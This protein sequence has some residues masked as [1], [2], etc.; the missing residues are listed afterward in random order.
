MTEDDV[1]EAYAKIQQAQD[2]LEAYAKLK[3]LAISANASGYAGKFSVTLNMY[4]GK[5]LFRVGKNRPATYAHA[6]SFAQARERIDQAVAEL[7]RRNK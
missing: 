1:V 7:A 2:S 6:Y 3:G 5:R 4:G